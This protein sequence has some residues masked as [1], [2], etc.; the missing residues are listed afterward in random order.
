MNMG[1]G[2]VAG[3]AH[4]GDFLSFFN[5]LTFADEDI[6]IMPEKRCEV[7]AVVDDDGK[8]IPIL[9]SGKGNSA[10]RGSHHR[11]TEGSGNIDPLMKPSPGSRHPP[12][13]ELARD[14]P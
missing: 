14:N 3:H 12:P 9:S 5:D 1:S 6:R 4:A 8:S 7:A 11:G 10:I 13:A 2:R